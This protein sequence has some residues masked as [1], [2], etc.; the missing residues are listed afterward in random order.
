MMNMVKTSAKTLVMAFLFGAAAAVRAGDIISIDVL[1][2]FPYSTLN[3]GKHYP[4][5][6]N[7]HLIGETVSIRIRLVNDDLGGRSKAYPWEF[8]S[9]S[10]G[11]SSWLTAPRLGLS[12][13]GVVRYA[14]MVSCLPTRATSNKAEKYFTDL[15]FEY[16][17]LPGDLAQPLKLLN[18]DMR[19][20]VEGDSYLIIL[21]SANSHFY[22]AVDASDSSDT[23]R[24]AEFSFCSDTEIGRASL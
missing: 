6:N 17:V 4:N 14:T 24:D 23:Q 22:N 3:G 2:D 9:L 10:S 18:S 1:E 19:E 12:V 15:I 8:V 13:G 7:P 20:A 21:P 16:E 11:E 5:P